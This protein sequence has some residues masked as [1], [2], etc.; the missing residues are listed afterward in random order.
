MAHAFR[1]TRRFT[2]PVLELDGRAVGGSTR[3]I[4]ELERLHPDPPLYPADPDERRRALELVEFFDTEL[5]PSIRRVAF[6]ALLSDRDGAVADLTKGHRLAAR[7]MTV[8]YPVVRPVYEARYGASA[9]RTG[10]GLEKTW[11]ALDRVEA[12]RAG[13]EH[14]VGD[15]FGAAD[16]TAAALFSSLLQPP[17]LQ[18]KAALPPTIEPLQAELREHP[19]GR[20]VLDTYRRHRGSS[21]EVGG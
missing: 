12:E 19:G 20:W 18:Y 3:I 13:R 2:F 1:L 5:G 10:E 7:A 14:L 17:E 4:A 11:A 15:T 21:A 6:N 8:A 9:A 16:L